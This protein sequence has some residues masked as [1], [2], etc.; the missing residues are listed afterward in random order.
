MIIDQITYKS[1]SGEFPWVIA[2]LID[3][4]SALDANTSVLQCG[5]SLIHPKVVLTAAHC[6]KDHNERVLFARAG[7]WDSSTKDE[8]YKHQ[9]RDVVEII[10]HEEFNNDSLINDIALLILKEPFELAPNINTICLPPVEK[11]FEHKMCLAAGWGKADWDSE[12]LESVM[13]R[14]QLPILSS[15][16]C[17]KIFR[18]T[19]LGVYFELDRS[20]ICA[21]GEKDMD[22]CIGDGG[23]PLMC[24]IDGA[25]NR[26]Y[27]G[28]IVSWG[29]GCGDPG[30]PGIC[31]ETK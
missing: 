3:V 15:D 4:N 26:Y 22:T 8:Y 13:K 12:R 31:F 29:L 18:T 6:I 23:S 10:K 9:D 16:T 7:D 30:I 2:L 14:I 19:R 24:E 21:G 28:G 25:E 1:I 20:I 17:Q 27:Q 11:S 5:G